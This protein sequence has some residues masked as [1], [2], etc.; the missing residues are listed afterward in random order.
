[1][2]KPVNLRHL[3]A[4]EALDRVSRSVGTTASH[5]RVRGS[6]DGLEPGLGPWCAGY[7]LE[8]GVSGEGGYIDTLGQARADE[9]HPSRSLVNNGKSSGH[10]MSRYPIHPA[11]AAQVVAIP[12]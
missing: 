11:A 6:A 4:G 9:S 1:M 3:A 12:L 8:E 10:S 2:A 5:Q 7:Y